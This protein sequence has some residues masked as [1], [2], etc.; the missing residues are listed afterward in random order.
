MPN[1]VGKLGPV[2]SGLRGDG[3]GDKKAPQNPTDKEPWTSRKGI[4]QIVSGTDQTR[5]AITVRIKDRSFSAILDSQAS[6][7]FVNEAV[8]KLL[9]PMK[10]RH[11]ERVMGATDRVT[12][13][14][15]GQTRLTARCLDIPIEV[16]VA[17][18]ENLV[19]DIILGHD[20]LVE[21][22]VILDYASHEIFL[23]KD[24]RLRVAWHDGNPQCRKTE[25][26]AS[27]GDI[28]LGHLQPGEEEHLRRV[29]EDFPEV[30][31]NNI[32]R[33]T[34]VSHTIECSNYSPIKQRPYPI[35]PD[36]RKFVIQKIKEMEG[37]GLIEPSTS[38]WAS[39]I[40][41]P[42]KKN[43]EYRLCVDFRKVNERTISDAYPMPD[44]K[45]SLRQVSGCRVF[46]TLDLNSGYWQVE[47]EEKSRPLTAFMTP[48]G[49]FQFTVMPFG[50]KMPQRRLCG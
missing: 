47:V 39:P 29:L 4:G 7:S 11:P 37:Q 16:D 13:S 19:P 33:T 2:H 26:K 44:L 38:G 17:V 21:Y 18:I 50:L 43:G 45:N 5:P 31:T 24:R 14:I 41:L 25:V 23:G 30:I 48:R 12:Y 27:L 35:N 15:Q 10:S 28:Q 36:K 42:K 3:T 49:L 22:N 46:S 8:A 20:F 9:P 40:V 6:N 32:G 34:T 1:V